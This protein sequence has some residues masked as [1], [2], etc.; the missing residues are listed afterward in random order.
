M[1]TPEALTQEA[2]KIARFHSRE[3]LY[4]V[5]RLLSILTPLFFLLHEL[6]A[7]WKKGTPAT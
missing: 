5:L 4:A 6:E 7:F 2:K 3:S 1:I